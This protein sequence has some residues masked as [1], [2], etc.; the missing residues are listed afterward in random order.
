ME[1]EKVRNQTDV[2]LRHQEHELSDQLFRLKFQMKMGQTESLKKMRGLRRDIARIKTVERERELGIGHAAAKS[3][4]AE[5]Q[6][7]ID[8]PAHA[9]IVSSGKKSRAQAKPKAAPEKAKKAR[10]T[11]KK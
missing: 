5:A 7:Q 4:A 1:I 9:R 2:E 3:V 6:T 11:E 10:K 8:A